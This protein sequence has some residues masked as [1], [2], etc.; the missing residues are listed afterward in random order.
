MS[1]KNIQTQMKY[2]S[3]VEGLTDE[4]L[5][6][7]NDEEQYACVRAEWPA[8]IGWRATGFSGTK[9]VCR[10]WIEDIWIDMRPASLR[11]DFKAVD[12]QPLIVVYD[13]GAALPRDIV[14]ELN[15]IA[16]LVFVI[17]A[18]EHTRERISYFSRFGYVIDGYDV[19]KAVLE[20]IHFNPAGI[21][22]FSER[23]LRLTATLAKRL[24]L[25]FHSIETVYRLTDK[26]K[27][28]VALQNA[29]IE[30]IRF[31]LI[32][33]VSDWE[34]AVEKV[35]LPAVLKP[36]YGGGSI[37]TYLIEDRA[38]G[39]DL[40]ERLLSNKQIG[41]DGGRSLVLEEFIE[42]RPSLPFG[43][44]VSVE[45]LV[46]DGK[47]KHINVTGKMP[48]SPPFREYGHIWPS[49]LND[50]EQ[51]QIYAL[52]ENAIKALGVSQG[53][54]HTELKLTGQGARIIEVNGRVGGGINEMAKIS[55]NISL[56][57]IAA[58]LALGKVVDLP[59]F[60]SE[61]V[62]FNICHIAPTHPCEILRV[63]GEDELRSLD[64]VL[65]YRSYVWTGT[66][67]PGGSQTYEINTVLGKVDNHE[68][69]LDIYQ[70]MGQCLH[71]HVRFTDSNEVKIL[72]AHEMGE[73]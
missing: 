44:Y 15:G 55:L 46:F 31:D 2:S 20:L 30:S 63:S 52:T 33:A 13:E 10:K 5:V 32:T 1:N 69:F 58:Q 16:P 48:L 39:K 40:V 73:I 45:S 47:I 71:F 9:E 27:Q 35:C 23:A 4:Y 7:V 19:E 3:S 50:R 54:T 57:E 62:Y 17:N 66:V 36:A 70:R 29:G 18:N 6:V 51:N 37:D 41:F 8:A 59:D 21:V 12:N 60:N 25:P 24:N 14:T 42:G 22:T 49:T 34:K 43:D 28:R 53:I 68:S 67:L 38:T 64:G 72:N 11:N 26:Y 65:S 61:H 56:L